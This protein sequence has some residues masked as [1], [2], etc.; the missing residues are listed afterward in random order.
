MKNEPVQWQAYLVTETITGALRTRF[1]YLEEDVVLV[2]GDGELRN[3]AAG[4]A[5]LVVENGSPERAVC[6]R[7]LDE[8]DRYFHGL[9][10]RRP[11]SETT[12][13]AYDIRT[14]EGG[15]RTDA[16]EIPF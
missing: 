5:L 2:D 10:G 7:L 16:E 14:P 9:W 4:A 13:T 3:V 1:F 12:K 15:R 11:H 8:A 6:E